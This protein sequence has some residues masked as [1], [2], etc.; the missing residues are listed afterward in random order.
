MIPVINKNVKK[1]ENYS[2]VKFLSDFQNKFIYINLLKK[3][4]INLQLK[5]VNNK[6]L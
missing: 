5:K 3:S 2:K 1:R 4:T 6:S